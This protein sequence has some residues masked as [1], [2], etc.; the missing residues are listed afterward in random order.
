MKKVATVL[1]A[2]AAVFS[3]GAASLAQSPIGLYGTWSS[4]R[5]PG[6]GGQV[7]LDSVVT[8]AAGEFVGRVS[9]SGSPCADWA[10]F[11][12]RTMGDTVVLSM[13]VGNCGPD[14]VTLHRQGSRWIG[15]YRT[16]Q[17][18]GTVE[19]VQ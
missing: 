9:F 6:V 13:I 4:G 2:I 19:M 17:D 3:G 14:A 16:P 1:L 15:T 18:L 11:S 7:H 5:Y 8:N 12:G 10:N